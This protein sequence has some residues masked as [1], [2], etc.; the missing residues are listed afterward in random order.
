MLWTVFF[1][2]DVGLPGGSSV[3]AVIRTRNAMKYGDN[4]PRS[5]PAIIGPM[6]EPIEEAIDKIEKIRPY[7]A[8]PLSNK[9]CADKAGKMIPFVIPIRNKERSKGTGQ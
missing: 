4:C 9:R 8:P 6:K 1:T 3:T 7:L 2:N 5:C